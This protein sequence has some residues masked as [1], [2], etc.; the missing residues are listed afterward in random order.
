MAILNG[1][2]SKGTSLAPYF[3]KQLAEHLVANSPILPEA[4]VNRFRNLLSR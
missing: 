2:G 1:M 3:G 4:D